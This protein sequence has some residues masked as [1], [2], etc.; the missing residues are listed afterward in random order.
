[1]S[2]LSIAVIEYL[3]KL[4]RGR[5]LVFAHAYGGFVHGCVALLLWAYCS[6]VF[7]KESVS[8]ACSL[9]DS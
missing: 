6:E 5:K 4:P 3:G 9:H 1:M 2:Q 8:G 7:H